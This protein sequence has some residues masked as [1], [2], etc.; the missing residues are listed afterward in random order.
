M[1]FL[2][3]LMKREVDGKISFTVYRK[4]THTD[5][6]LNFESHHPLH[7]K[8]GVVR[9]LLDR[10]DTVVTKQEDKMKEEKHIEEALGACGYPKWTIKRVK[11][12]KSA[13][14]SQNKQQKSEKSEKSRGMVVIPYVKGLSE[15]VDRVMRKHKITTAMKPHKTVI[16]TSKR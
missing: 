2:D 10:C 16:S 15:S 3:T 5:Q 13:S 11:D 9:T 8:L 12:K 1:P 6:Y 14:K 4:P 7:Q